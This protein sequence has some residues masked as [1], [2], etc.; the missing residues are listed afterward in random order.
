M[1]VGIMPIWFIP[2]LF[3]IFIFISQSLAD[4]TVRIGS[5]NAPCKSTTDCIGHLLC[6]IK[7]PNQYCRCPVDRP[8]YTGSGK[9][10]QYY[11]ADLK[12]Y[13]IGE[14]CSNDFDCLGALI[15]MA[16][17]RTCQ[18]PAESI[19]TGT[20]TC[21]PAFPIPTLPDQNTQR[22]TQIPSIVYHES[23]AATTTTITKTMVILTVMLSFGLSQPPTTTTTS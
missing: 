21:E 15:C 9:C 4:R 13:N 14:E 1:L 10:V 12:L 19:Y 3:Y 8:I 6:Q 18:C 22:Y 7:G 5:E 2:V 16:D 11:G 23:R 20:G 17:G